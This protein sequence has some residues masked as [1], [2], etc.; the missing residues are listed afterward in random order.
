M[1]GEVISCSGSFKICDEAV[2]TA[3]QLANLNVIPRKRKPID[4]WDA[5]GRRFADLLLIASFK[6]MV[7]SS[8]GQCCV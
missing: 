5:S 7:S 2:I 1:A 6:K 3:G 8:A 4:W